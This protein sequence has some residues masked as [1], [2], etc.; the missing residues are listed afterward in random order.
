MRVETSTSMAKSA[1]AL[2]IMLT[3]L[4]LFTQDNRGKHHAR[5]AGVQRRKHKSLLTHAPSE[6]QEQFRPLHPA[7][8][9]TASRSY[10]VSPGIICVSLSWAI[11][12]GLANE[13]LAKLKHDSAQSNREE[14]LSVPPPASTQEQEF[15]ITHF[16]C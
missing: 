12:T 11:A 14:N 8:K 6:F 2:R 7:Q 4:L 15:F 1:L 16:S 13:W 9:S 5:R 10:T 3:C